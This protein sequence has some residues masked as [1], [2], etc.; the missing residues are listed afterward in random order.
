MKNLQQE[1]A[2]IWDY[3]RI[4]EEGKEYT[5]TGRKEGLAIPNKQDDLT[6]AQW[7]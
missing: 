5:L 4:H 6:K 7:Y 1:I 3:Q 2:Y